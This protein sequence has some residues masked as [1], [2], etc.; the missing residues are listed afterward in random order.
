MKSPDEV[1]IFGFGGMSSSLHA[2]AP[3]SGSASVAPKTGPLYEIPSMVTPLVM[4]FTLD[5][6]QRLR[7]QVT[8]LHPIQDLGH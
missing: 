6:S 2:N 8:R 7:H 4:I 1:G 5:R 3:I